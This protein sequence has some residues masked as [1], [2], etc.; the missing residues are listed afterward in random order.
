MPPAFFYITSYGFDAWSCQTF[1]RWVR[2]GR[3]RDPSSGQLFTGPNGVA[4]TLVALVCMWIA[5]KGQKIPKGY[6]HERRYTHSEN[7]MVFIQLT[8]DALR[9]ALKP[10]IARLTTGLAQPVTTRDRGAP[11]EPLA[12]YLIYPDGMKMEF[13]RGSWYPSDGRSSAVPPGSLSFVRSPP[14]T[15][16]VNTVPVSLRNAASLDDSRAV[17]G[18]SDPDSCVHTAHQD[19]ITVL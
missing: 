15:G 4:L 12:T 1:L 2:S 16:G 5:I 3:L 8:V 7:D 18:A 9:I 14:A 6:E 11:W 17:L 19:S 13:Q 10:E